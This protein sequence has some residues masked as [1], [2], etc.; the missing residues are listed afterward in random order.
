MAWEVRVSDSAAKELKKLGKSNASKILIYLRKIESRDN[1]RDLGKALKGNLKELWRYRV[2]DYRII[3]E[4]NDG[5]LIVLALKVGH[6]KN[7][8]L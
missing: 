7:I 4:I 6:R 5:E 3:C 8:Y 1:P 2:G